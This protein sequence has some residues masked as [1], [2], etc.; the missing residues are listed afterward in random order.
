MAQDWARAKVTPNNKQRVSALRKTPHQEGGQRR[1]LQEDVPRRLTPTRRHQGCRH[2]ECRHQECRPLADADNRN[3]PFVDR[4]GSS[5]RP[6][7]AEED[8]SSLRQDGDH[9]TYGSGGNFTIIQTIT[10]ITNTTVAIHI[11]FGTDIKIVNSGPS[12]L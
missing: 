12:A 2:Q 6:G 10:I 7:V 9:L 8:S 11:G 5:P 1:P 4:A 3:V